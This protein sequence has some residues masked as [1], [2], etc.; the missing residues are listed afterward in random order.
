MGWLHYDLLLSLVCRFQD[1]EVKAL[2]DSMQIQR[3]R[4]MADQRRM[5]ELPEQTAGGIEWNVDFKS[6]DANFGPHNSTG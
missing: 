1:R 2:M 6:D 5:I 4:S 3:V